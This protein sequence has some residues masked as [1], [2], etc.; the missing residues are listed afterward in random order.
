MTTYPSWGHIAR[1]SFLVYCF[2]ATSRFTKIWSEAF[3]RI[4]TPKICLPVHSS[5]GAT[6]AGVG[7]STDSS[8]SP[9]IAT[10]WPTIAR[11]RNVSRE[12]NR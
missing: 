1:V 8:A 6:M 10:S 4:K 12:V 11:S 5:T 9:I 3:G 2:S 7:R